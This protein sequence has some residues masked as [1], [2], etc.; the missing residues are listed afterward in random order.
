M[1]GGLDWVDTLIV[2]ILLI[3]MMKGFARGFVGELGGVVAVVAALI[4]PWY[5]NGSFDQWLEKNVHLGQGSAHVVGMFL[6]GLLTYI[7][8]LAVAWVVGRIA[9]LPFFNI[10]NSG[11][12]AIVGLLKSAVLIWFILFVA[13]YFPLSKD[14]RYD[15]HKS[16]LAY[17]FVNPDPTIDKN[18]RSVI[19][20]YARPAMQPYFSRHHL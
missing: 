1:I 20:W 18:I 6:T 4:A 16:L 13:L 5:Y 9:K 11:G 15:L 19:P 7:I 3:G 14:L 12:G 2:V 17:T 10:F 8:V